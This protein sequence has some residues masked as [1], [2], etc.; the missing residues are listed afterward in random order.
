MSQIPE[1]VIRQLPKVEGFDIEWKLRY[2]GTTDI[3]KRV[4]TFIDNL[5]GIEVTGGI[6]QFERLTII[7]VKKTG[8]ARR[9]GIRVG[10]IITKINDELADNMTLLEAQLAIH[11]SGRF[12]KI[13]VK[14]DEDEESEDENTVD[15]Y[16]KPRKLKAFM[17]ALLYQGFPWNDKRRPMYKESN[18][19]M[20]PSKVIAKIERE[21]KLKATREEYVNNLMAMAAAKEEKLRQAQREK[22][23]DK[24]AIEM[25]QFEAIARANKSKNNESVTE[26]FTLNLNTTI[27]QDFFL[28]KVKEDSRAG[29]AGLKL[30]DSIVSI[31]GKDT[32]FMTLND[33]NVYLKDASQHN[34]T[35]Q[36]IKFTNETDEPKLH[37]IILEV[38]NSNSELDKKLKLMQQQLLE[39]T[40]IP[41]ELQSKITMVTKAL[42]QFMTMDTESLSSYGSYDYVDE[43]RDRS[44]EKQFSSIPEED[45]DIESQE[46]IDDENSIHSDDDNDDDDDYELKHATN[47]TSVSLDDIKSTANVVAND[48]TTLENESICETI[49]SEEELKIEEERLKKQQKIQTLEQSWQRLCG[50]TKTI[51]KRSNCHLVPSSALKTNKIN[52]LNEE[53]VI[54]FYTRKCIPQ[55]N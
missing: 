11:E 2:S 26:E 22:E 41:D 47:K 12:V 3:D 55:N 42:E 50:N 38:P 20:V 34:I 33:A 1:A 19:Y 10:D 48:D 37:E 49:K 27:D 16:F 51:Y 45:E 28:L 39:M 46:S 21:I 44:S 30:G 14:G 35:L 18:C 32:S 24:E 8:L 4:M 40:N 25:A 23:D 53:K 9:A 6:D 31:N 5:W 29:K 17:T 43:S 36:V 52:Q 7:A 54:S 15:F 13:F